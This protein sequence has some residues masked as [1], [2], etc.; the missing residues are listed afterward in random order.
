MIL[1]LDSTFRNI[2]TFPF[3]AEF[4]IEFNGQ[5]PINPDV[6]DLRGQ[7]V[8]AQYAQY[9]FR[10]VGNETSAL[11]G[12]PNDTLTITVIPLNA[13]S[14]LLAIAAPPD[15]YLLNDYFVGTIMTNTETGQ[16]AVVATYT[17]D[18]FVFTLDQ[19]LFSTPFS[20]LSYH[21]F[22]RSA[23]IPNS[24][25]VTL[26]NP[27][28]TAGNNLL[29]LGSTEL[30]ASSAAEFALAKGINTALFVENVTQKWSSKIKSIVGTYRSVILE[31]FPSYCSGDVFLVWLQNVAF[32][33]DPIRLHVSGVQ[34]FLVENVGVEEY[35]PGE[36]LVNCDDTIVFE[37]VHGTGLQLRC[38]EAGSHLQP[39]QSVW[40]KRRQADS[41]HVKVGIIR[42]GNWFRIAADNNV[43]VSL[44]GLADRKN[45][46]F[47]I[48]ILNP[49]NYQ[50]IYF[51]VVAYYF[52]LV[53]LNITADQV[54]VLNK[55]YA[56]QEDIPFRYF[57]IPFFSLFPSINAP[58]VPYQNGT[59]Y[60]VSISSISL[61]NLP[62]CGFDVLLSDIPYILVTL[63]NVSTSSNDSYGTL[64][65]NNPGSLT[66]N[67][68]C[69][70]AN[71]RNPRIV[72]FVVVSSNQK[73]VFK[74]TP[75]NSLRF[76]VTLPNGD[77]LRYST[78]FVP[79]DISCGNL[80]LPLAPCPSINPPL[81][82]NTLDDNAM[83][84][85]P[86]TNSNLIS[87]TFV[88]TPLPGS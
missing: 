58:V 46:F 63:V 62:V 61:P 80:T 42:T 3:P 36:I 87:A 7:Y 50:M 26:T 32:A 27:T 78:T 41:Y 44:R 9:S 11:Y 33:S 6:R 73:T 20:S 84:V 13:L 31:S 21:E 34:D 56:A 48:G 4:E 25:R 54:E 14:C 55:A 45:P 28:N 75:R 70:I 17:G 59:C 47:L 39:G 12:V 15:Y 68:V 2:K 57:V 86:L 79:Y 72:K 29:I 81:N 82:A 8:T 43:P 66:A 83:F 37:V 64:I 74:F 18:D 71:I 1:H 69:P 49:V 16:S 5:P 23:Q 24:V 65:S 40:V 85:Y 52:P 60:Q 88:F 67:F 76:R 30:I 19:P 53:Y 10:W 22:L 35:C 77:L 38:L 51:S